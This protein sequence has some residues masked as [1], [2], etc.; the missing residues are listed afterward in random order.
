MH[1]FSDITLEF[2]IGVVIHDDDFDLGE[3][4]TG[5]H[6]DV[7]EHTLKVIVILKGADDY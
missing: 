1:E 3:I 5:A 4:V 7:V 2:G 6:D